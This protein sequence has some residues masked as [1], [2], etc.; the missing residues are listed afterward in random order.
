MRKFWSEMV[1]STKTYVQGGEFKET[2]PIKLNKNENPELPSPSVTKAIK[3]ATNQDLRLYPSPTM[4]DLK[5][6]IANYY[7][8]QAENVFVGNGSDEVLAFS[9]MAFFDT[10]QTILF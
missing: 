8:L 2:E 9:F 4:D 7:E 3:E 5:E 1:K 10:N 6:S